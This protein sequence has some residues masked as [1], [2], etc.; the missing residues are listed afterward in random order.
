MQSMPAL[1]SRLDMEPHSS[2]AE[3]TYVKVIRDFAGIEEFRTL[4]Q[5]WRAHPNS[6]VDFCTTIMRSIPDV[7]RPHVLVLYRGGRPGQCLLADSRTA[8]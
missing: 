7:V 8:A 6:D 4:W 1:G 2:T 3:K 5:D